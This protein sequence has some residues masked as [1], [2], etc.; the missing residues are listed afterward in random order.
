MSEQAIKV[1]LVD[2]EQDLLDICGDSFEMEGY[3]VVGVTSGEKALQ[4]LSESDFDV[5]ISDFM[6]PEMS[7]LEFLAKSKALCANKKFPIFIFSTGAVDVNESDVKLKG[8]SAI[9]IKPF[10]ID[11]LINL[12]RNEFKKAS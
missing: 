11:E 2:D 9:I 1:L 7:G 10:D 4:V 5:V 6:M 8:A 3:E 12:V